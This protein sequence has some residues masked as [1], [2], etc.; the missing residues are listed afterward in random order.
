MR[1]KKKM[2]KI[3]YEKKA[4][5]AVRKMTKSGKISIELENFLVNIFLEGASFGLEEARRLMSGL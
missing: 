5:K 3:K 1:T 4:R 2:D